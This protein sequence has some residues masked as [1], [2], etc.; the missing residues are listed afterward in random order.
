MGE[1]TMEVT[2]KRE[3][4]TV[5]VGEETMVGKEERMLEKKEVWKGTKL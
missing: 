3:R 1:E 2:M 5:R 4:R